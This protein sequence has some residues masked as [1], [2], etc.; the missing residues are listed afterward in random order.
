[1]ANAIQ[2]IYQDKIL[3]ERIGAACAAL[4]EKN[5]SI[6][7]VKDSYHKIFKQTYLE[8]EKIV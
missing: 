4:V 7:T 1:M 5:Y 6:N 8:R 3:A 2:N